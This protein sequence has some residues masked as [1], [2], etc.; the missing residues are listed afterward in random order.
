MSIGSPARR[1]CARSRR[2]API[3]AGRGRDTMRV[4]ATASGPV[5]RIGGDRRDRWRP[6]PERRLN[7]DTFVAARSSG[8][9]D[10]EEA[11]PAPRE[12]EAAHARRARRSSMRDRRP[13]R[14]RAGQ[15]LRP[16][17]RPRRCVNALGSSTA[18]EPDA[19][20]SVNWR[21]SGWRRLD[22]PARLHAVSQRREQPRPRRGCGRDSTAFAAARIGVEHAIGRLRRDQAL[23]AAGSPAPPGSHRS[24]PGG[25]RPRQPTTRP[26]IWSDRSTP[27]AL[28]RARRATRLE[29]TAGIGWRRGDDPQDFRQWRSAAPAPRDAAVAS[30][31]LGVALLQLRE[32]AGVLDR[33]DGLVRER[34]E[35]RHLGR[36]EGVRSE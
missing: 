19:A 23:T 3:R 6:S 25:R 34:F 14:R 5:G 26:P 16:E 28:R 18:L 2:S 13:G 9:G 31:K 27:A 8:R 21:T 32:Q 35:L 30:L 1:C 33:D 36:V 17:R 12:E 24:R 10:Q 22:P 29:D 4:P 11:G 20:S 15:R 7:V